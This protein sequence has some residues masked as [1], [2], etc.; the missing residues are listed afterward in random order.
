M[1]YR[2]VEGPD[3]L[4]LACARIKAQASTAAA[5]PDT[6]VMPV[7]ISIWQCNG[8]PRGW[9]E[10][11]EPG[12]CLDEHQAIALHKAVSGSE[13]TAKVLV[14]HQSSHGST[15]LPLVE[16]DVVGERS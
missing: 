13:F 16:A 1:I 12:V 2:P 7:T 5:V 6:A 4:V 3:N 15:L 9:V 11:V 8:F 10:K 14:V